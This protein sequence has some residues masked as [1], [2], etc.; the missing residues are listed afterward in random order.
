MG[1]LNNY[2]KIAYLGFDN[3]NLFYIR[4][5][6]PTDLITTSIPSTEGPIGIGKKN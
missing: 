6:L 3:I 5:I 2:N 4:D 1:R